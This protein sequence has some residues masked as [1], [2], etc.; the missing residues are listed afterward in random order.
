MASSSS[1]RK[2]STVAGKSVML[3]A[4]SDLSQTLPL[5]FVHILKQSYIFGKGK[6]VVKFKAL[7]HQ[8]IEA[9]PTA[10]PPG[11][12]TYIMHCLNVLR[13]VDA[14]YDEGLSH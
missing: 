5:F 14:P 6:A 1:D 10:P 7:R 12:A 9:L 11:P 3:H 2:V 4:F 13:L 8:V